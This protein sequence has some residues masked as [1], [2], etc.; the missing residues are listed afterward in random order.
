LVKAQ[1]MGHNGVDYTAHYMNFFMQTFNFLNLMSKIETIFA[2]MNNYFI[3]TF[4]QH[5]VEPPTFLKL[6]EIT[7]VL[8]KK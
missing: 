6:Q 4:K 7:N 2:F 1:T 3:H 8:L 5:D